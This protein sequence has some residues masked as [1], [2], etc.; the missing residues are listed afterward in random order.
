MRVI[1][2]QDIKGLGKK[3]EVKEIADGYVRNF[4][5]PKKLVMIATPNTLEKLKRQKEILTAEHDALLKKLEVDA[6]RLN[7]LTAEFGLKTGKKGEVFGSIGEREI[8]NF[9]K[10]NGFKNFKILLEHP[11]K[12]IGDHKVNIDFG[13]GIKTDLKVKTKEEKTEAVDLD[14]L[15]NIHKFL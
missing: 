15:N 11:I 14:H 8:G 4:L 10:N 12:T 6:S 7:G 5:L 1:I 3:Y 13:G 2:L 9:L